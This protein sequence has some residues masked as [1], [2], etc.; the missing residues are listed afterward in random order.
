MFFFM[1]VPRPPV[2]NR[3]DTL[4]PYTTLIRSARAIAPRPRSRTARRACD[5]RRPR[6]PRTARPAPQA[7]AP[8]AASFPSPIASP[9]RG[10]PALASDWLSWPLPVTKTYS[11][12]AGQV[13]RTP[14]HGNAMDRKLLDILVCRTT[15]QPLSL[16]DKP[17]IELLNRALAAGG[18]TPADDQ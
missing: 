10:P 8:R 18:V 15:R 7:F 5:A 1:I 9:S 11:R 17:G 2:S 3:T 6:E 12:P 13:P 16:L 4:F 14:P